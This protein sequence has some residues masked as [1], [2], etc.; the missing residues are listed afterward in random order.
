MQTSYLKIEKEVIPMFI[1]SSPQRQKTISL[2]VI[3][4]GLHIHT[5]IRYNQDIF[6]KYLQKK[7]SWI[8]E[9]WL[10]FKT[11]NLKKE[12]VS[13]ESF[14]YKGRLY[15]LK[16]IKAKQKDCKMEFSQGRFNCVIDRDISEVLQ[17]GNIELAMNQWYKN[18]AY[19]IIVH[20]ATQLIKKYNFKDVKIV[21]KDYKSVYGKCKGDVLS[22]NYNIVKFP[23]NIIRHIILHE[24]C[25]TKY[26][27]HT[28]NF[29]NL[30]STL[31]IES[32]K[33]R[34]W[35]ANL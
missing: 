7:H 12:Y 25:H 30:L 21:I 22:F 5:P 23:L 3:N 17:R 2:K 35:L 9:H 15:R 14:L 1:K 32:D 11:K 28:K 18:K 13:G 24:L 4:S 31:D 16:V 29:W 20:E 27:W 10:K 26:K 34:K 8:L 19:D 6:D 33:H